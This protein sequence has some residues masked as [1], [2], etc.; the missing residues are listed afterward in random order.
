MCI[1]VLARSRKDIRFISW[2]ILSFILIGLLVVTSRRWKPDAV[3]HAFT[4]LLWSLACLSGGSLIGFLFG[5]P[6]VLQQDIAVT[7]TTST[8]DTTSGGQVV[9]QVAYRTQVNT[10]L[11]KISDWLTTIFVGL[12][13][14]EL[15][16]VPQYLRR[17]S[18][19]VAGGVGGGGAEIF[20][21]GGLIIYFSIVGFVGCYLITRLYLAG[22]FS[23]ADQMAGLPLG[24]DLRNALRDFDVSLQADRTSVPKLT[25]AAKEAA[26]Q[27]VSVTLSSLSTPGDIALWAKAQLST[28]N[29]AKAV[30]G[31]RQAG[32][33]SPDDIQLRLEYAAALYYA[34]A[35]IG[36]ALKQL[37][38][39]ERIV[40]VVP[41]IDRELKKKVYRA[42][43]FQYLFANPPE[44]F[45]KTI[46]YAR[47]YIEDT[48]PAKI[49]SG[50]VYVNLA[51][52]YGQK[53]KW[54]AEH[55]PAGL[56]KQTALDETRTA[57]LDA[58]KEALKLDKN[59]FWKK[60]L[61]ILLQKNIEK[62]P[63]DD[64]LEVFED[65][66]D[67]RTILGLQPLNSA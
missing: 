14:V 58:I 48:D 65:D 5:I 6:R 2:C 20:F 29:Y 38:Q 1:S 30:E 43:T 21:A 49:P 55:E 54:L 16:Q 31:Y 33:K 41:E 62:S 28:G 50:A 17:A 56:T 26:E 51:A 63:L 7:P 8:P 57:A 19:F 27:I 15:R 39:A 32:A 47:G 4:A 13:L 59:D 37:E 45:N 64:D 36:Q 66:A 12:G 42:I 53:W 9:Q 40:R 24:D 60:R 25:G 44:S 22:A 3:T 23:R 46:D 61:Q 35:P 18:T 11:E 10:N 52:A 34:R 67:F